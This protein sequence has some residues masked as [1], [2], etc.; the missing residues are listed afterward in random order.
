MPELKEIIYLVS[1]LRLDKDG[2]LG[3]DP[4]TEKK[5]ALEAEKYASG[6]LADCPVM[7]NF[8]NLEIETEQEE[9]SYLEP[10]KAHFNCRVIY[11]VKFKEKEK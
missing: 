6:L 8:K 11:S 5:E 2:S 4:E 7:L 1:V 9:W 10:S 3:D